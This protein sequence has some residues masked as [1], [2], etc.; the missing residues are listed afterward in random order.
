MKTETTLPAG[1]DAQPVSA[2]QWVDPARLDANDYNPNRVAPPELDLLKVSILADGWTQPVVVRETGN[3][4]EIVDGFHRWTLASTDADVAG[5]TGGL[6]PVVV[7]NPS[8]TD[9]RM[10]TVRHNRARGTHHVMRMADIVIALHDAGVADDT[11]RV[12][13]GMDDEELHRFLQRGRMI[14]RGRAD[15]FNPAW[16]PAPRDG[17]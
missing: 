5:L 14:E 17:G 1:V 16:R 11:I 8:A 7:I 10:S 9:Q 13:L 6:V 2:V 15:D 3:R 4:F 12:G